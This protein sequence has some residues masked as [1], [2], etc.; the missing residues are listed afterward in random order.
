M[1]IASARLEKRLPVNKPCAAKSSVLLAKRSD[2][3]LPERS[4]R[5]G[6]LQRLN[7]TVLSACTVALLFICGISSAA[8]N[9][10]KTDTAASHSGV[11]LSRTDEDEAFKKLSALQQGVDAVSARIIQT[12]RNP[13]LAGQTHSA[14]E[15]LLKRPNL[16]RLTFTV[17][18][19]ITTI[20]DGSYMWVYRPKKKE[21][22]RYRLSEDYGKAQAIKFLANIISFSASDIEKRFS[23]AAYRET[24]GCLFEMTP[25]SSVMAKFLTRVTFLFKDGRPVPEWFEVVGRQGASTVT[26]F[27]DVVINPSTDKNTFLF[28]PANDVRITNLQDE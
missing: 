20:V 21:A 4:L 7:L 14:G 2:K 3:R 6:R 18:E 8:T 11:R 24:E 15:I 22:E 5:S 12:K 28:L 26:E 27:K 17:P 16:L 19:Q 23:I 10:S 25:K 9:G 13:L 1:P